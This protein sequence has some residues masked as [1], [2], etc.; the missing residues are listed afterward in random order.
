VIA[1]RNPPIDLAFDGRQN[2]VEKGHAVLPEGPADALKAVQ[3]ATREALRN[4]LLIVG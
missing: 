1:G 3:P 2:A 4:G